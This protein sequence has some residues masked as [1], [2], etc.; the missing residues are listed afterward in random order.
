M[1]E[2]EELA[3]QMRQNR[4]LTPV[5]HIIQNTP[6]AIDRMRKILDEVPWRGREIAMEQEDIYG[7]T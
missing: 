4:L 5:E 7:R 6:E 1:N 2:T 3:A